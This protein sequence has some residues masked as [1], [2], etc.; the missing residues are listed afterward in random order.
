MAF[1]QTQLDALDEAIGTGE[2][3]VEYEGRR[4][5]YRS[6]SELMQ[7][8][9]HVAAMLAQAAN[10]YTSSATLAEFCRN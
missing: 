3:E 9:S 7:A 8:R 1:T 10:T 6:I 2:L 5:R 4:I